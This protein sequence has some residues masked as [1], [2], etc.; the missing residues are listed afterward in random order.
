MSDQLVPPFG[1]NA[2]EWFA[3]L[4]MQHMDVRIYDQHE[5]IARYSAH[6]ADLLLAELARTREYSEQLMQEVE[7]LKKIDARLTKRPL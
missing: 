5:D 2:R 3:G 4:A 7:N 6:M 1:I